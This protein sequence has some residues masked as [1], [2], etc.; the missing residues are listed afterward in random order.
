MSVDGSGLLA[1][2]PARGGSKGIPRKNLQRVGG[3][4]LIAHAAAAARSLDAVDAAIIT[5]DDEE[6]AEE[7]RRHGLAAPFLRPPELAGDDADAVATW[8]HAWQ[9]AERHFGRRFE[10][11]VLL[12]PSSPL[13]LPDDV[14]R[15]V[16]ALLDGSHLAAATVS[17]TPAHYTPH[18][19]LI[20]DEHG[21]LRPLLPPELSPSL[22]Q[23]IPRQYHRNGVC[24]AV[25]R[26]TLLE[27]GTIVEESCA[28]VVVDR[29]VV[30]IDEPFDLELAEWLLHRQDADG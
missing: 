8:R 16:E 6:M 30:N 12:E 29:P 14:V 21:E 5:T 11:S 9:E 18:K 2:I 7:G 26:S 19:T 27:G 20:I 17:R 25:R 28:A 4:S 1:V 3:R 13:R 23:M 10:L 15:T 22:R 24:Y